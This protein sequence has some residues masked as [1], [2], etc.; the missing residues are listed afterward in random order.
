MWAYECDLTGELLKGEAARTVVVEV[1]ELTRFTVVVERRD[2]KGQV[3]RTGHMSPKAV[4]LITAAA[5][6]VAAKAKGK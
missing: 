2:A 5:K 4:E 3:W 6:S 1:D